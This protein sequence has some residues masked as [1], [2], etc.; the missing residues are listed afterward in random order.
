MVDARRRAPV[1][2]HRGHARYLRGG[3]RRVV[4]RVWHASGMERRHEA[5]RSL[6]RNPA[7]ARCAAGGEPCGRGA[8]GNRAN[9]CHARACANQPARPAAVLDG[10]PRSGP[11]GRLRGDG[12]RDSLAGVGLAA[13]M[14]AAGGWRIRILHG[15]RGPRLHHRATAR[16]RGHRGVRHRNRAGAVGV[17]VSGAVR[18][19]PG[20]GRTARYAGVSRGTDLFV[21]GE[22]RFVLPVGEDRQAE[23]V[24][25]YPGGQCG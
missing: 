11:R 2:A 3:D 12:D 16:P 5:V 13:A 6:F 23:M 14:E 4:R 24:E 21:G 7:A 20:R 17:R 9:H 19:D 8:C 10:L 15:G 22:G 1:G 18:R 25:E